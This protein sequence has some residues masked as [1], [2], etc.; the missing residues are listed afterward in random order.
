MAEKVK[1]SALWEAGLR[2]LLPVSIALLDEPD[3]KFRGHAAFYYSLCDLESL[4]LLLEETRTEDPVH[5]AHA[6]QALRFIAPDHSER[7]APVLRELLDDAD[8]T[9]RYWAAFVLGET[10]QVHLLVEALSH[11]DP[12]VRVAAAEAIEKG[13][14]D[15]TCVSEGTRHW[16]GV[17][18][19]VMFGETLRI[20]LWKDFVKGLDDGDAR[21]RYFIAQA[22]YKLRSELKFGSY[23]DELVRA[24]EGDDTSAGFWAKEALRALDAPRW[25]RLRLLRET[26]IELR[27]NPDASSWGENHSRVAVHDLDHWPPWDPRPAGSWSPTW[28]AGDDVAYEAAVRLVWHELSLLLAR[29]E[30][31]DDDQ[32]HRAV[33]ELDR[34]EKEV[35]S[36]T[37]KLLS[38]LSEELGE[39]TRAGR[40]LLGMGPAVWDDL[41]A[42]YLRFPRFPVGPSSFN[43]I[44]WLLEQVGEPALPALILGLEHWREGGARMAAQAIG[45]LGDAAEPAVLA[46]LSAWRYEGL[47]DPE[48]WW[49]DPDD[50][51]DPFSEMEFPGC[52]GKT[53]AA[54]GPAAVPYLIDGLDD[55]HAVVRR[56]CCVALG[57]F[58]S[59]T[60]ESV[61]AL[62]RKLGDDQHD[63][64]V[65]A[66]RA[67]LSIA[68]EGT[69]AWVRAAEEVLK[70]A[71]EFREDR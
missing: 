41:V 20:H 64:K 56:R 12:E 7:V 68:G 19:G 5:R 33:L 30:S 62:V 8:A 31:G 66:A 58:G 38:L 61:P 35:K 25:S 29:T 54:I 40:A 27:G 59:E 52:G 51:R 6:I 24:A 28:P 47:P 63:V 2:G 15:P 1:T 57:R 21:V 46:I 16:P 17:A 10:D 70:A 36:H 39:D 22:I 48:S 13:V 3:E 32:A 69:E 34:M 42:D 50:W 49:D 71:D 44:V 43:E 26:L 14:R 60:N 55:P 9:C 37:N 4:P 23:R 18:R 11:A 65:A 67:L 45:K 53:L